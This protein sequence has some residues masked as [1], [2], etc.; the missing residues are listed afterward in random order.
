MKTFRFQIKL[1]KYFFSS[2]IIYIVFFCTRINLRRRIERLKKR[3][4]LLEERTR[5]YI[6][7]NRKIANN[8]ELPK[9]VKD[10]SNKLPRKY[11]FY[12]HKL[13][14][15]ILGFCIIC[16]FKKFKILLPSKM[17]CRT[18]LIFW[19]IDCIITVSK[20]ET[21]LRV[22]KKINRMFC[23]VV[24]KLCINDLY[25]TFNIVDQC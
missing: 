25:P 6:V 2:F 5:E 19:C 9:L 13:G 22:S 7:K 12:M 4:D 23:V 15:I 17:C 14:S 16:I 11:K 20:E 8:K 1:L 24:I 18:L 10:A 21:K 3:P